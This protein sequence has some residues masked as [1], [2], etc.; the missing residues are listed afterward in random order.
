MAQEG[1][2]F[3][4]LSVA[5]LSLVLSLISQARKL[6]MRLSCQAKGVVEY[7][8]QM[9]VKR[10]WLR[11]KSE[12][13]SQTLAGHYTARSASPLDSNKARRY[14]QI[15]LHFRLYINPTGHQPYAL[16]YCLHTQAPS[17]SG[18]ALAASNRK[19]SSR[20]LARM[21][22]RSVVQVT[23]PSS[24]A[25]SLRLWPRSPARPRT[26]PMR[27]MARKLYSS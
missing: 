12:D 21:I 15:A 3:L 7:L 14:I 19:V 17:A 9:I 26:P 6:I 11:V 5:E 13:A 20:C 25:F 22:S 1:K 16:P 4:S 27:A 18:S 10:L 8:C 2:T 23:M 24:A